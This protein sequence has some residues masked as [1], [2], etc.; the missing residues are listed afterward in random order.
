MFSKGHL[1]LLA[2]CAVLIALS[3][4]LSVRH[5]LSSRTAAILFA[6]IC[7]ASE[8]TKNMICMVPSDF[9]G[10]VLDH[11][12]LPLHLC[13]IVVF[14]MPVIVFTKKEALR[15]KL[16]SAVTVVGLVAPIFAL[17]IPTEGT[18]FNSVIT[19]Q[20]FIYHSAL[21]W[22][23]LHH[24]VTGQAEL[25]IRAYRRN[26]GYASVMFFLM[27]YLNSAFSAYGV[28][29]CFLREPPVDGIPILN[30]DHG[31]H[32]YFAVLVGIAYGSVTLVHLP[33]LLAER[34]GGR[35]RN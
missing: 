30:L 27:L 9:G 33:F 11:D 18:E 22:F 2:V 34:R 26:L 10:Y 6:L 3:T 14:V 29:F 21:M 4:V 32:C 19:Y 8:I 31:W 7:A 5:R 24:A 35:K 25:G 15:E 28:N 12:D 13:S 20:Y 17:L 1:I 23:A 16:L